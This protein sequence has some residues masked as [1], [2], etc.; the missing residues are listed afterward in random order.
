MPTGEMICTGRL[1]G[2]DKWSDYRNSVINNH[3]SQ[4]TGGVGGVIAHYFHSH[5]LAHKPGIVNRALKNRVY[6]VLGIA[7]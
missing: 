3:I 7:L 4:T 6:L 5:Q 2:K 1:L